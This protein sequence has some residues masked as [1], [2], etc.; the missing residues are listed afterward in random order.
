MRTDVELIGADGRPAAH[1]EAGDEVLLRADVAVS[2]PLDGAVFGLMITSAAGVPVYSDST[3]WVDR[4]RFEAGTTTRF[5]A[6][7]RLNLGTGSYQVQLWLRSTDGTTILARNSSPLLFYV[8]GRQRVRGIA[9]LGAELDVT[10]AAR[11]D[12]EAS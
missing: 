9:D 3:P 6:R 1:A 10:P 4:T 5:E 11:P 12:S 2:R 7:M 8:S